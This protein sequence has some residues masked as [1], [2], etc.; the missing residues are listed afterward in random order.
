MH[1]LRFAPLLAGLAFGSLVAPETE[2]WGKVARVANITV[3]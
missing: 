1:S 2:K 3:E